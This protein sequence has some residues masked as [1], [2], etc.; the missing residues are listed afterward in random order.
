M[1]L[2]AFDPASMNVVPLWA[3]IVAGVISVFGCSAALYSA[4]RV[5]NESKDV[6]KAASFFAAE[7]NWE[8]SK[9]TNE[10]DLVE[11]LQ[12][13]CKIKIDSCL[14]DLVRACWAAWLGGRSV[15]LTELHVLVSRRERTKVA[16]RFSGG[17][18]GLLLVVGIAG[19]LISVK[20]LLEAFEF[21]VT[22]AG[23]SQ[24]VAESTELVNNLVND[25]GSAFLPSLVALVGTILVISVRGYYFH[26]LNSFILQ[27]DKLAIGILIPKYRPR[28]ISE[29]YSAT[30]SALIKLAE[31]VQDREEKFKGVVE[32]LDLLVKGIEPALVSLKDANKQTLESSKV[33]SSSSES[34]SVELSRNLGQGSPMHS[35]L[36]QID[37]SFKSN[38]Q[39]VV[40]LSSEVI[41]LGQEN[42]SR[43]EQVDGVMTRMSNVTDTI[44]KS[45]HAEREDTRSFLSDLQSKIKGIPDEIKSATKIANKE[46]VGNANIKL[47]QLGDKIS[48]RLNTVENSLGGIPEAA[49]RIKE[50]AG[51]SE[52]ITAKAAEVIEKQ[53]QTAS[54]TLSKSAKE[55]SLAAKGLNVVVVDKNTSGSGASKKR[56]WYWPFGRKSRQSKK[57]R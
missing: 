50:L 2:S 9:A 31:T 37:E 43:R 35:L 52:A 7:E 27:L 12:K 25:L 39:S 34:L 6:K 47:D 53:A 33:L 28:S 22:E 24:G 51:Q 55:V 45:H 49:K 36:E 15:S 23:E 17:I 18:A 16:S 38:N 42:S 8:G 14:S 21:K 44:A 26:R 20:P 1:D 3:S 48:E 10:T 40:D 19:T 32:K 54:G 57:G 29:E 11:W 46:L 4:F 13:R 5:D 41:K 30:N 56:R